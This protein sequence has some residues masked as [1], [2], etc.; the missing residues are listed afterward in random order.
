MSRRHRRPPR[1]IFPGS[2]FDREAPRLRYPRTI[3]P[4]KTRPILDVCTVGWFR[5]DAERERQD[6]ESREAG[7]LQQLAKGKAEVVEHKCYCE[8][9]PWNSSS[10]KPVRSVSEA[11]RDFP[12]SEKVSLKR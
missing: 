9:T 7:V 5:P 8:R 10:V 11:L 6:G 3:R 4:A 2:Q 1:Q 12:T